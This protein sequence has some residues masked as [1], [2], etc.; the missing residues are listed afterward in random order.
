MFRQRLV[1]AVVLGLAAVAGVLVSADPARRFTDNANG[2]DSS[3]GVDSLATG[4]TEKSHR[5][6]V[7]FGDWKSRSGGVAGV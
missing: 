5:V 4:A 2:N 1:T 7:H 6:A 3:L